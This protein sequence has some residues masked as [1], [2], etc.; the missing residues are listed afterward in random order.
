MSYI[1]FY[2]S[3]LNSFKGKIEIIKKGNTFSK[4]KIETFTKAAT[5]YEQFFGLYNKVGETI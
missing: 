4:K 1:S 2:Y 5:L 3:D